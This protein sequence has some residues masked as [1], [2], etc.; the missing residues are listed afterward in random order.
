MFHSICKEEN[1]QFLS[2]RSIKISVFLLVVASFSSLANFQPNRIYKL[3]QKVSLN[4]GWKFY[5]N[6]PTGNPYETGYGDAS[7]QTVNVPHSAMYV[8]PTATA[9]ATT[10]P[11]GS[12]TGICW[13]RKTFTVP[14]G[15][16]T[17]KVFL[18]FEGAMQSTDVYLNGV[19]IGGHG[20]SGY[21][22]FNFDISSVVNR[23][24]TNVLAVRLDCNYKWEIPPGNV[25][26]TGSGGEYPDFYIYSGLHRDVWLVCTDNVYIPLYGQK[27]TT[28]QVS[29]TSATVRV[30]TTVN[31]ANASA[32][33]CLVQSVV[34][35]ASGTIVAQA[36]ASGSV[37]AGGS[38]LFDC[39]TPVI[40]NP[41]LWSPETPNLYRVFTKVFVDNVEVDDNVE[42]IGF[43]TLDW[44]TAGGFF[45]NG[46]RYLLKGVCMHQEFAW[47]CNA[48]PNSRYYE[49]VRLVK[50]MG[51]NAIR[52]AHYPRDPAFYDACD[53]LGVLCEPEL[54]AWGGSITSYP[55][56][57]WNRMDTCAQEMVKVAI[58]HPSIIMWGLFNE[59]AGNFPTQFTSLHNRIKSLDST[60]FT[61]VINN[62]VQSANTVTNIFGQNYSL[63]WTGAPNL[64]Y[65]AEYHQGWEFYC[66]RGDT[67]T[68]VY[69]TGCASF[70]S[71]CTHQSEN[72]FASEFWGS[73]TAGRSWTYILNRTGDALPL[74]GGHAW[75]FID[76]W[77]PGNVGNEPMGMIDHYRIPKKVFY[78]FR[79][80]W[81]GAAPDTF[82]TGLTPT[83]V[84]LDADLVTITADSTDITRIVAS[85]RD[86]S[87]RCSHV[88]RSVTLQLS[89][90]VDCFDT[91]TRTT[92]A[93][94]IG[95]VL[96]SRN[97]PG[98]IIA[99]VTS[100]G[101][102][103]DTVIIISIAPDNSPL[104]FIWLPTGIADRDVRLF[105]EK[106]VAVFQ[107][108]R[109]I[110]I[111]FPHS[112]R[113]KAAISLLTMQG[114][115]VLRR[116]ITG[117]SSTVLNTRSLG[118]GVY[119]LNI[120]VNSAAVTKKI[121]VTP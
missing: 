44:R 12:W 30:R 55:T 18:E 60:R 33:N 71:N 77:T 76:Y 40:P 52:C 111:M 34:V 101:L 81:T 68:V 35:N 25:P 69:T 22:G 73:S 121:V 92:I 87:G 20:A 94:K 47:V 8:A 61:S 108:N 16:H 86:A 104:P 78:T 53:E 56:I 116:E 46:V 113:E 97:T 65:N 95:W 67:V 80:N 13:Y 106:S 84:Q 58:N 98:A 62:K 91:L 19:L 31:N 5:L 23:T 119:Y 37:T 6:N 15:T 3:R 114:R 54:P 115:K 41:G 50:N 79:S 85:M 14:A 75:V 38:L 88:A 29:S 102:T 39:T 11:S 70:L 103:P 51:A 118:S 7:W 93:G 27:I 82:V 107:N 110:T 26:G 59:A 24:G 21:T 96:K 49:E 43:R 2:R 64:Y 9:E 117:T 36:S 63:T 10:R 45:L 100:S 66:Y 72:Q 32:A 83:R 90:P 1:M 28:P 74:A 89:G 48:L 112:F 99:I 120:T 42:R 4:A 109:S 57:F 17:Q 105:S